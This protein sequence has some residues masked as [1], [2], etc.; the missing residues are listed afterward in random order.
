MIKF[1]RL[2]LLC[3][4]TALTARAGAAWPDP[5]AATPRTEPLEIR[6]HFPGIPFDGSVDHE[7]AAKVDQAIAQA[8]EEGRRCCPMGRLR[9]I[10]NRLR[11]RAALS[12]TLTYSRPVPHGPSDAPC[13]PSHS[14]C[15]RAGSLRR[16]PFT[17]DFLAAL[18]GHTAAKS[19]P[20]TFLASL[21]FSAASRH[22]EGVSTPATSPLCV[23]LLQFDSCDVAV[24]SRSYRRPLE[25]VSTT[26]R[27][28]ANRSASMISACAKSS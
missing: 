11:R 24:H 26:A 12:V 7:A 16:R 27:R 20:R 28:K 3:L 21:D 14:I 6:V 25:T 13:G 17:G 8:V 19:Q 9:P 22:T 5:P 4:C 23:G 2:V 18:S 1:H 10:R 15:T